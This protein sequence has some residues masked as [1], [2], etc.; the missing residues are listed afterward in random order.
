M[1]LA[2]SLAA[3]LAAAPAA[4]ALGPAGPVPVPL[5]SFP[6]APRP[7]ADWM[8]AEGWASKRE[9]PGHWSVGSGVLHMAGTGDS[10][11]IGTEK[12]FPRAVAPGARLR[13]TLKV[14]TTPRGTDLSRKA[15]DDAALRLYVAFDK[16]GGLI[17]PPNTLA[18][19]WTEREAAGTLVRSAH[20]SN[21]HYVSLGSG[22]TDWVT[23][24]CDLAAD[25]RRAFPK[26]TS[27]PRLKGLLIKSDSNDTKT[28]AEAW[29]KSVELVP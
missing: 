13:L 5:V 21:L 3:A 27:L 10:V 14:A 19:A 16:G 8:A 26:E 25:Y 9:D 12:G 4:P 28:S 15:G 6:D 11:L 24:E 20:F 7:L 23:V 18:Y 29:L 1:E 22:P 17:S 2:L